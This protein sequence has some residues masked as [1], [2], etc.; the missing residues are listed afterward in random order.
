MHWS[1]LALEPGMFSL[2]SSLAVLLS[3]S[4]QLA[5]TPKCYISPSLLALYSNY[6]IINNLAW[7]VVLFAYHHYRTSFPGF[8]QYVLPD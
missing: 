8:M 2:V 7:T 6:L 4:A 1:T 3:G 5:T